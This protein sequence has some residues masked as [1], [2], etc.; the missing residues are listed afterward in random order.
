MDIQRDVVDRLVDITIGRFH[1]AASDPRNVEP[2]LVQCRTDISDLL[3]TFV[4]ALKQQN[5]LTI[6][7]GE[8]AAKASGSSRPNSASNNNNNNNNSKR[9]L[10]DSPISSARPLSAAAAAPPSGRGG[11]AGG[12]LFKQLLSSQTNE[13]A[14]KDMC[15]ELVQELESTQVKTGE[16]QGRLNRREAL[17]KEMRIAYYTEISHFREMVRQYRAKGSCSLPEVNMF[18]W[19]EDSVGEQLLHEHKVKAAQDLEEER[20]RHQRELDMVYERY[21]KMNEHLRSQLSVLERENKAMAARNR[22]LPHHQGVAIG[23]GVAVHSA[24]QTEGGSLSQ[25]AAARIA[26]PK[27]IELGVDA[28]DVESGSSGDENNNNNNNNNETGGARKKKVSSVGAGKFAATA[29]SSTSASAAPAAL[30][31]NLSPSFFLAPG[32]ADETSKKAAGASGL[33]APMMGTASSVALSRGV[34]ALDHKDSMLF[35]PTSGISYPATPVPLPSTP[36]QQSLAPRNDD[37]SVSPHDDLDE[38]KPHEQR[39]SSHEPAK[40]AA[41]SGRAAA[42][43][44]PSAKKSTA[45]ASA[46]APPASSLTPRK[47]KS[48]PACAR[49][50]KPAG[51]PSA[52]P[53]LGSPVTAPLLPRGAD[54]FYL[55]SPSDAAL[56]LP[57]GGG[58]GGAGGVSEGT[59][60]KL[61]DSHKRVVDAVKKERDANAAKLATAREHLG[62]ALKR[63]DKLV[64]EADERDGYLEEL[65][66]RFSEESK[67]DNDDDDD[68]ADDDDHHHHHH[69]GEVGEHGN[70]HGGGGSGNQKNGSSAVNKKQQRRSVIEMRAANVRLRDELLRKN[71]LLENR[72]KELVQLQEETARWFDAFRAIHP[73]D[74]SPINFAVLERLAAAVQRAELAE[75]RYRA[76]SWQLLSAALDHRRIMEIMKAETAQAQ[77]KHDAASAAATR[78]MQRHTEIVFSRLWRAAAKMRQGRSKLKLDANLA[79]DCVLFTA[80]ALVNHEDIAV[81]NAFE[82][83]SGENAA[84]PP[85]LDSKEQIA[86][87]GRAEAEAGRQRTVA[88]AKEEADRLL[89]RDEEKGHRDIQQQQK[90]QQQKLGR[91]SSAVSFTSQQQQQQQQH[92]PPQ[93]S[94][95]MQLV[96]DLGIPDIAVFS[97]ATSGGGI[98]PKHSSRAVLLRRP[99]RPP[100]S[101]MSAGGDAS[102][103]G[104]GSPPNSLHAALGA[105]PQTPISAT[106]DLRCLPMSHVPAALAGHVNQNSGSNSRGAIAAGPASAALRRQQHLIDLTTKQRQVDDIKMR[107]LRYYTNRSATLM[108]G[109][110]SGGV[111]SSPHSV[112]AEVEFEFHRARLFGRN[113]DV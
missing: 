44:P 99:I 96:G 29:A 48:N 102:A 40:P 18:N 49:N 98:A 72:T 68:G 43:R 46:P 61:M 17:L 38:N 103:G 22:S 14:W 89:H 56:A 54:G 113:E 51:A 111:S 3:N 69:E 80:R 5:V 10:V 11:A 106:T 41:S 77:S 57:A 52:T 42:K 21:M 110:A 63:I 65:R 16:L 62:L 60:K 64:T 34:S 108:A 13:A 100:S 1:V 70:A 50:N 59:L 24:S 86:Q 73:A 93:Q 97:G 55:T 95:N 31:P 82:L 36:G 15:S 47:V 79:W 75:S 92:S 27:P 4:A 94:S 33:L 32:G 81:V 112:G 83:I 58:G 104:G 30:L 12:D 109:N 6:G 26:A 74:R 71:L 20:Q 23:S 91:P 88:K 85:V 2:F 101:M 84:R 37:T 67:E 90:R 9:G 28:L 105:R 8:N 35:V 45:L 76:A 107:A 7:G 25:S 19:K 39:K 78:T 87:Q 53:T 66:R